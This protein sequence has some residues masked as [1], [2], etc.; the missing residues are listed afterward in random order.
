MGKVN[1]NINGRA[2]G[3]GCDDGDEARLLRL[4]QELDTRVTKIADQ[5][6]QIG[7]LRLMV[8]AGITLID[9]MDEISGNVDKEVERR[10]GRLEAESATARQD[11][12]ASEA[13]AA[14][15]LID[16]AERIE[17][18]TARLSDLDQA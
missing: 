7:D 9:E 10:I 11:R 2:Y 1:L 4:G 14:Q 5:F 16:A 18:L 3:L 12:D 8:M 6:G 17:R 13:R 15:N